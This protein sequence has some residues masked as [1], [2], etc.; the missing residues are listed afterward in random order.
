MFLTT[1]DFHLPPYQLPDLSGAINTFNAFIA[2][3]EEEVLRSV[4]GDILFEAFK[5][6][7][8]ETGEGKPDQRWKDIRDGAM[9]DNGVYT[10]KWHGLK[11]L[12]VP[13]IHAMWVRDTMQYHTMLGTVQS[14]AENGKVVNPSR[15]IVQGYNEFARIAGSSHE[16]Q[17]TLYGFLYYSDDTYLDVL[18]GYDS[19]QHYLR[20]HF[21]CPGRMNTLN[22]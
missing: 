4:L 2:K 11:K 7:I 1:E 14:K 10:Y 20:K 21:Q 9:Y 15:I 18:A 22:I 8:Q 19:I 17:G 13:N 16:L 5:A 12:L 6:G 3:R